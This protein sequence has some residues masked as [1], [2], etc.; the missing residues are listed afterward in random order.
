MRSIGHAFTNLEKP[1]AQAR[2]F[3]LLI[4]RAYSLAMGS[5]AYAN[6][7]RELARI[8]EE[9]GEEEAL[10]LVLAFRAKL[11]AHRLP[12][13][14]RDQ[15]SAENRS[16][17]ETE[18]ESLLSH[19]SEAAIWQEAY[20]LIFDCRF[21]RPDSVR[22]AKQAKTHITKHDDIAKIMKKIAM[23]LTR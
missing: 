6:P 16:P 1:R 7:L 4:L 3:L 21:S 8:I 20:R 10:N 13:A 14:H 12:M 11:A 18:I 9:F 23:A 19:M 5:K 22:I 17:T 2:G 15:R